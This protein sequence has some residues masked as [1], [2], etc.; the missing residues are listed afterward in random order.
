MAKLPSETLDE[1]QLSQKFKPLLKARDEVFADMYAHS[2][3]LPSNNPYSQKLK[4]AFPSC[5]KFLEEM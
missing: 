4:Q 2:T 5:L 1:L 3:G